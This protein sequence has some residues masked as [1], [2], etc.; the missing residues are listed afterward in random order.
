MVSSIILYVYA[1][2]AVE[3]L[4]DIGAVYFAVKLARVTG[5]FRGW[6]LMIA[7]VVLITLQTSSSVLSLILFFPESQ[8]ESLINSVGNAA[9]V[10]GSIFGIGVSLTLFLAMLELYRTFRRVQ[11]KQAPTG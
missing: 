6:V 9:I 3:L 7:A 8:L 1:Y 10:Q 11:A 5:A 2:T 4:L